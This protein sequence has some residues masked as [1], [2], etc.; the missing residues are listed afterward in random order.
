MSNENENAGREPAPAEPARR[1]SITSPAELAAH[2]GRVLSAAAVDGN[3]WTDLHYAAALDWAA[4]ARTLLAVGAQ[5]D[6]PLRTDGEALGLRLRST[7]SRC[8]QDR[9][10]RLR[11]VGATP[12]HIAAA[13]DA[14]G[15]VA[16]LLEGG[17]DP[18][19]AEA[20]TATPLHYA[21][22]GHGGRAAA[23][24]AAHGADVGAATAK[25]VTP[26]HAAARRDAVSVVEAL[27]A[28]GADISARDRGGDT[29]L[30]RAAS[31]DAAVATAV[32]L[33]HGADISAR[34]ADRVTPLHVA[35]LNE[36]EQAVRVLL[37]RGADVTVRAAG[38]GTP[39]HVA[40]MKDAAG[41]VAALLT[42]GAAL[43]APDAGGTR[44]CTGRRRGTPR[45]RWRS[46]W[47]AGR[48]SMRVRTTAAGRWTRRPGRRL[49]G[50][51]RW[52]TRP[53]TGRR[54]GTPRPRWRSCWTAGRSSMRVRTTA[55]G[56]WT[57]RPGRRL[58]GQ[59]RCCWRAVRTPGRRTTTP[60]R[61]RD[62]RRC[63]ETRSVI[64]GG[65]RR[66]SVPPGWVVA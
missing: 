60:T 65:A 56:R 34:A 57:R 4:L 38:G 53:C 52:G 28:H 2:L 15:V 3:G 16:V 40:A 26:L 7:L 33:N 49:G 59:G 48:S 58:G 12:L 61:M 1:P 18:D 21:A 17:A 32:L 66:R 25:G 46:C 22:A 63:I 64:G 39:L 30:H 43:D 50:Q 9:L 6:A 62:R 54:R 8:G 24:L 19:V 47:T 20:T 29:P 36:A 5:V 13:A 45:P 10:R 35:A 11:R 44:P 51:G 42:R 27:L 14:R 41:I 23:V 31:G 55:A 37:G